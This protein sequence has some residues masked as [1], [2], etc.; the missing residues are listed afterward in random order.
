[1]K[2]I[3]LIPLLSILLA[4]GITENV[5]DWKQIE[6][7]I[8]TGNAARL[9]GYFATTVTLSVESNKG[10]FSSRQARSIMQDFFSQHPPK[11]FT[12]KNTGTTGKSSPFY[13]C[14]YESSNGS[15]YSVYLLF[16]ADAKKSVV[17]HITFEKF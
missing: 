1:M 8:A 12:V 5:P 9:S 15:R 2:M 11:S 13:L 10:N 16:T 7:A 6:Q 17:T 3:I 4:M 14:T